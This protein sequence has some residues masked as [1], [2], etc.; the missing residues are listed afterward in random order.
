[1]IVLWIQTLP[2]VRDQQYLSCFACLRILT[3]TRISTT[4]V[5]YYSSILNQ[6]CIVIAALNVIA[7]YHTVEQCWE[8]ILENSSLPTPPLFS[9]VDIYIYIYI[10]IYV[11]W[12][13]CIANCC[14][15]P[16]LLAVSKKRLPM[17]T[18]NPSGSIIMFPSFFPAMIWVYTPFPGPKL[19]GCFS[20]QKTKKVG[21]LKWP[22]SSK[23]YKSDS[24]I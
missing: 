3:V 12:G 18:P 10:Y 21:L 7:I 11:S 19:L 13:N 2:Q 4:M 6:K 24:M 16:T 1:M 5:P 8:R 20:Q 9:R 15:F 17:G 23:L 22:K 14:C